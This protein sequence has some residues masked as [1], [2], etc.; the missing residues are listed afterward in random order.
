MIKDGWWVM[1]RTGELPT[2]DDYYIYNETIAPANAPKSAG[3]FGVPQWLYHPGSPVWI[4]GI[5][6]CPALL[7]GMLVASK[8]RG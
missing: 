2:D 8:I 1:E 5:A 3:G 4:F 7:G 6:G